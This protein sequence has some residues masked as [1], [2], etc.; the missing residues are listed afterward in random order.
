[1][2]GVF[3]MTPPH[4]P[5]AMVATASVSRMSRARYSSPAAMADSVL[6]MPPITVARA[7]GTASD[8]YGSASLITGTQ[9]SV[10]HGTASA[11]A[12]AGAASDAEPA[13]AAARIQKIKLP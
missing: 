8:R 3:W 13:P 10:G 5:A 9:L 4:M 7:K 2:Y 12:G 6:S 11:S 1:M